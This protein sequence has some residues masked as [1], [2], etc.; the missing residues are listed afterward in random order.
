MFTVVWRV[1][2]DPSALFTSYLGSRGHV[3]EE[4]RCCPLVFL[5]L[6]LLRFSSL[7]SIALV[8]LGSTSINSGPS[9]QASAPVTVRAREWTNLLL[10]QLVNV[11]ERESEE[12]AEFA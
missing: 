4:D 6:I 2:S 10:T 8:Q 11:E 12:F 3:S 5:D 1:P 7:Y 9:S